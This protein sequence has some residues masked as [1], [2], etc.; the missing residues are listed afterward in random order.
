MYREY[1]GLEQ[2]PFDNTPDPTFLYK[3]PETMEVYARLL[4]ALRSNS[5]AIM[6]TGDS[7]CGKTLMTRALIQDLDAS[8]SEFALLTSPYKQPLDFLREILYQ[9]GENEVAEDHAQIVHRLNGYLYDN[10]S[11]GKETAIIVDEGQL[12]ADPQMFEQLRLL[13]NFQLNDAFLLT[14][15]LVGQPQLAQQVMEHPQLDERLSARAVLRPFAREEV[16][17]YVEHRLNVAG[18]KDP[19]FSHAALELVAQYSGGI[20][21]RINQICDI[22]LVIAFSRKVESVEEDLVY[23]LILN[24]EESRV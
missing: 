20:P 14:L 10:F 13:L 11:A 12:L 2:R 21:R 1:W 7:G 8:S 15:V 5:G 3:S 24:E 16:G 23:R 9:L 17:K 4:Y 22:C 19:I 6:L 18:R